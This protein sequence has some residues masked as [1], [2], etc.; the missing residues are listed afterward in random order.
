MGTTCNSADDCSQ[1]QSSLARCP[2]GEVA[3]GGGWETS[4]ID[5]SVGLA[6]A[7]GGSYGIVAINYG[8]SSATLKA[9]AICAH[10]AGVVAGKLLARPL[11][12]SLA[13]TRAAVAKK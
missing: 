1:V 6:K 7:G 2:A 11:A 9:N 3:S 10:G 8:P 12:H 13:A 5:I 4:S